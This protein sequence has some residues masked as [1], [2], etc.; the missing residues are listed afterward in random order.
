MT[1][2][3]PVRGKRSGRREKLR[4]WGK[5]GREGRGGNTPTHFH[6]LPALVLARIS[7]EI[8]NPPLLNTANASSHTLCAGS[9]ESLPK[10]SRLVAESRGRLEKDAQILVTTK[11]TK[12]INP[13]DPT[14]VHGELTA[15]HRRWIHT[16]PRDRSGLAFQTHHSILRGEE[17]R[18]L[19]SL[20]TLSPS[21]GSL[22]GRS[23]WSDH[24]QEFRTLRQ[25]G[26]RSQAS[27]SSSFGETLMGSGD[28]RGSFGS[29]GES[30]KVS[31]DASSK[32]DSKKDKPHFKSESKSGEVGAEAHS[33]KSA[34]VKATPPR[35]MSALSW[36]KLMGHHHMSDSSTKTVEDFTSIRRTG[37]DWKSLTEP[38]CLPITVDFFP[39]KSK[40]E[41]D[42]YES[43]SKLVVSS[44]N[45]QSEV[46]SSTLSK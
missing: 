19:D 4:G 15:F 46:F 22:G 29:R 40:L 30:A 20:S 28:G 11:R 27:M 5:G 16:F 25:G 41:M 38:A 9:A 2:L 1:S 43:P 7:S 12:F 14:K 32:L 36:R 37:V 8:G 34:R 18:D 3:Q 33:H 44:Y 35:G 10:Y 17:G 24:G 23:S 31:A 21:R 39:S 26:G 42:Y 45:S 13:F 6:V